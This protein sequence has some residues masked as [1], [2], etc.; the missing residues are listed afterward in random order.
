MTKVRTPS[1]WYKRVR[2]P[3]WARS[4]SP[5]YKAGLQLHKALKTINPPYKSSVPVICIGNLTAGGAGKTPAAM[6][7]TDLLLSQNVYQNPVFLSRGYGSGIDKPDLIKAENK[8]AMTKAGD[9][10][11][12]L[13]RKA[14]VIVSADRKA[15][16]MI[17]EKS[18]ADIIIMDD[19]LQNYQL[20]QD[21]K[22]CVVDGSL[23][24]GNQRV[25]PGG[26]LREDLKTGLARC[27]AVLLIGADTRNLVN[28]TLKGLRVFTA[29]IRPEKTEGL[30]PA[31]PYLA[32]AGIGI[33]EK[34][35]RTLREDVQLN[36]VGTKDFPDHYSYKAQDLLNLQQEASRAGAK[37]I[38][39]EK[40][41]ARL[42]DLSE[43][44]SIPVDTLAI[45]LDLDHPADFASFL[46]E[47]LEKAMP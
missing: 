29:Q 8:T 36:I 28:T 40:D 15:G 41:Y 22:I 45:T 31:K 39:T 32:F 19:G 37:L 10:V 27:D 33:P 14:P 5:L 9:E 11:A 2:P 25:L 24:F 18:G 35:Y 26:P 43:T 42:A 6:A 38:T 12:L 21:V 34:F 1:F 7:V 47:K 44:L 23:G 3:L 46:K 17:A 30:N 4:L 20:H 16:A 13:A